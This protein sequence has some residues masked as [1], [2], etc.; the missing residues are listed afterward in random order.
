MISLSVNVKT[1][2]ISLSSPST[3]LDYGLLAFLV[4]KLRHAFAAALGLLN[5]IS[6]CIIALRSITLPAW[7]AAAKGIG[8]RYSKVEIPRA[9]CT[10][11]IAK[12]AAVAILV[13]GGRAAFKAGLNVREYSKAV[14]KY[15][16][17]AYQMILSE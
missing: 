4:R 10:F 11:A 17:V 3:Q 2:V 12:A 9:T 1:S 16:V 5:V 7:C 8:T 14:V 15:V 13:R 6:I